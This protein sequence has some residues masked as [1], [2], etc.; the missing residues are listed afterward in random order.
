MLKFQY[1]WVDRYCI[2]QLDEED[3]YHRIQ[4]MG[5]IY[6][7]AVATIIAAAG[8]DPEYGLPGVNGTLRKLQPQVRIRG[9][10]LASTLPHPNVSVNRSTWNTRAWTFQE[11]IPSK[12]RILFTDDQVLFE[13]NSMHCTESQS[14]ILEELHDKY[15]KSRFKVDALCS[16]LKWKTPTLDPSHIIHFLAEFSKKE[17]SYPADAI[18]AM[19]GIFQMFSKSAIPV[20]HL[21][22][23]PLLPVKPYGSLKK[24]SFFKGL[25]WYHQESW[26]LPS[27]VFVL[28]LGRVGWMLRR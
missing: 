21:E 18:N 5:I 16:A 12:R 25:S 2:D 13:C 4:Q 20:Y 7:N 10:L 11:S 3:K 1:L 24:Y 15:D 14:S 26:K 22:G 6:A 17:L 19:R 8:D 9:H 23:V 28:V 27:R